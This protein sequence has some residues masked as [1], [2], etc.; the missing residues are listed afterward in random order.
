MRS[1]LERSVSATCVAGMPQT[2]DTLPPTRQ[3][4]APEP[5]T[6]ATDTPA[7]AAG[8]A[9]RPRIGWLSEPVQGACFNPGC[10]PRPNTI[11][12]GWTLADGLDRRSTGFWCTGCFRSLLRLAR[13]LGLPVELAAL[14]TTEEVAT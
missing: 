13:A 11:I 8:W 9:R 12:V 4:R 6:I 14:R 1:L 5:G 7:A 10:A 2:P 3:A